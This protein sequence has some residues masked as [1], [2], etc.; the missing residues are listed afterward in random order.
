M[1]SAN[2]RKNAATASI[3]ARLEMLCRA[4][5]KWPELEATLTAAGAADPLQEIRAA[6]SSGD[7]ENFGI[8]ELLDRIDEAGLSVG[9]DGVTTGTKG[10]QPLPAGLA[11][12]ADAQAWVCPHKRCSRVVLPEESDTAPTCTLGRGKPMTPLTIPS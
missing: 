8:A 1:R 2:S 7:P 11:Q 6:V 4:I 9:L 12:T 10:Y 5:G 3:A